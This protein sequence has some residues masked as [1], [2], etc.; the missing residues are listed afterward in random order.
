MRYA[1]ISLIK[2]YHTLLPL[3]VNSMIATIASALLWH[4]L[5]PLLLLLRHFVALASNC[6]QIAMLH[7]V[8]SCLPYHP[9]IAQH[10]HART[11]FSFLATCGLG[12]AYARQCSSHNWHSGMHVCT[13]I[14]LGFVAA[15]AITHHA[16]R[17]AQQLHHAKPSVSGQARHLVRA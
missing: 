8:S 16:T 11:R 17:K 4:C 2:P 7:S 5:Q 10:S 1:C 3:S 9:M 13:Y 6:I 12:R 14:V 15:G